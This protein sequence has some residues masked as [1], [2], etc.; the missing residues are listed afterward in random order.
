MAWVRWR[1]G[2]EGSDYSAV[3]NDEAKLAESAVAD[4]DERVA[5]PSAAFREALT[6]GWAFPPLGDQGLAGSGPTLST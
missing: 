6:T 3:G 1:P 5:D 4:L 2:I